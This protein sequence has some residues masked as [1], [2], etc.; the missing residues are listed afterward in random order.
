MTTTQKTRITVQTTVNSSSEAVWEYFTQPEHIKNWNNASTDWHTSK[1]ENDLQP[2]GSFTFRMEAKDGS[3]GFDFGGVYQEVQKPSFYSYILEDGR[4][5]EVHF[6]EVPAGVEIT[7]I[8][9]AETENSVEIQKE[10]W[11]AI[12]DNF[13]TYAESETNLV[14]LH[15]EILIHGTPEHVF[16]T[17][18]KKPTY[19]EW[20]DEF[21][22]GSTYVGSWEEGSKIKFVSQGEEGNQNGLVSKVRKVIPNK[23]VDVEH[24]G[25]L[26]D[27]VEI[28]E[29]KEVELWKGAHEIYTF[30]G[31][32]ESTLLLIDMHSTME[33]DDYFKEAWPKALDKLKEICERDGE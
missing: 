31:K 18:L 11:Q 3:V 21:S 33:F 30:E 15:F 12:L 9:D 28:F 16:E 22:P 6:K 24:L 27:G 8:F 1:A 23:Y 19:E 25:E 14:R 10:G 20:T 4:L 5:V 32:G 13:K 2:G 7:E 17:M 26:R 29:G